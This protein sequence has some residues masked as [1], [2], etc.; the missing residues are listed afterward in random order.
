MYIWG[1]NPFNN[2]LLASHVESFAGTTPQCVCSDEAFGGKIFEQ[3][4]MIFCD[5]DKV[6]ALSY[7]RIIQRPD[8]FNERTLGITLM[9]VQPEQDL[10]KEIQ[11][12]SIHGIFYSNDNFELI[13]KG[14]QKVLS[15]EHWLTRGLLVRSLQSVRAEYRK[16]KNDIL[17]SAL[18]LREQE[19]LRLIAEGYDNQAIADL[20]FISPNTVKTHVSNIYKKIDATNRV[21]AIIWASEH[22]G[23][24]ITLTNGQSREFQPPMQFAPVG[25]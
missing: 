17:P 5:C 13:G 16:E 21:Q 24:L 19:I 3:N 7:C 4:S 8:S 11:T 2:R 12:Y 18:T 15:G 10:L 22:A 25:G 9:N 6:D 1:P 14:I 20:L 23:Q